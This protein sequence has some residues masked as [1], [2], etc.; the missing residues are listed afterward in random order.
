[1]VNFISQ[2]LYPHLWNEF[3][4]RLGG[5]GL[6]AVEESKISWLCSL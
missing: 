1:M 4:M 3:G 2:L 6:D 5:P